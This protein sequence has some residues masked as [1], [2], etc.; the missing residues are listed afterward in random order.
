MSQLEYDLI[1]ESQ[2]L[3][4][5]HYYRTSKII[6]FVQRVTLLSL[7]GD[8]P[9]I[10]TITTTTAV[11]AICPRYSLQ[12]RLLEKTPTTVVPARS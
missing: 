10:G 5:K 1:L 12:S 9:V 7:V 11:V 4:I 2:N 6:H 3:L 8:I